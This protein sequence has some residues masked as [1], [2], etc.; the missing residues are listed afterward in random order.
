[1]PRLAIL[2]ALAFFVGGCASVPPRKPSDLTATRF[3]ELQRKRDDAAKNTQGRLVLRFK[4][5]KKSVG[6]KGRVFSAIGQ[7]FRLELRDPLGR[8]RFLVTL[9]AERLDAFYPSENR[10]YRDDTA[11]ARYVRK[12]LGM[13]ASFRELQF[14]LL[15]LVPTSLGKAAP[16][17]WRWDS[18][19]GA[20][21][22]EYRG[23]D[24]K[25]MAYVDP[26]KGTLEGLEIQRDNERISVRFSDFTK[27]S[28]P[29]APLL[30]QE[31]RIEQAESGASLEGSW[32]E[33][34]TAKVD[35]DRL[36]RW[37][38]PAGCQEIQL[39]RLPAGKADEDE[40]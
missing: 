13:S 1:M 14:L 4:T 29:G 27:S 5:K 2:L 38:T 3:L 37:E 15:G 21:S 35:W 11:G 25:T 24:G 30:P 10:C 18:G 22:L 40:W 39:S 6:G 7:G 8:V 16:E 20:F 36:L 12:F 17:S 33:T 31:F 34:E 28:L 26:D 32:D 19:R 9:R 23:E